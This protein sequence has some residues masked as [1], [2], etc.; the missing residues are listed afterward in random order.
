MKNKLNSAKAF[1][2]KHQV[3]L[4]VAVTVTSAAAMYALLKHDSIVN[5][6]EPI[7]EIETVEE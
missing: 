6:D 3:A 5:A 2:R 1:A 4:N 7:L